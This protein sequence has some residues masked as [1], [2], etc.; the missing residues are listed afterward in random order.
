MG[1]KLR[2]S[3]RTINSKPR[4]YFKY[5]SRKVK[6]VLETLENEHL[7][8]ILFNPGYLK[9]SHIFSEKAAYNFS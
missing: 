7:T 8:N 1:M 9:N 6:P 3:L 5:F 2:N 4:K